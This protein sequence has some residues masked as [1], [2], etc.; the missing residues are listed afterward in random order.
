VGKREGGGE[1]QN[2]FFPFPSRTRVASRGLISQTV[3]Y[4]ILGPAIAKELESIWCHCYYCNW[5]M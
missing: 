2:I 5:F 3:E 1:E 4:F